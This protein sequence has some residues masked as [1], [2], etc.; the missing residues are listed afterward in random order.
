MYV[1]LHPRIRMD[2]LVVL[3]DWG[4]HICVLGSG[5][6]KLVWEVRAI[7]LCSMT[8]LK[9]GNSSFPCLR[10]AESQWMTLLLHGARK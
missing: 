9:M 3:A 2:M 8:A 5:Q 4:H 10:I 1:H 7:F 6:G